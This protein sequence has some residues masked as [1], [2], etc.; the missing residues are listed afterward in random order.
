[1]KPSS[2][3]FCSGRNGSYPTAGAAEHRTV[4]TKFDRRSSRERTHRIVSMPLSQEPSG[5]DRSPTVHRLTF[6][7]ERAGGTRT[8]EVEVPDRT[9]VRAALRQAGL[10]PEGCLVLDGEEPIPLDLPA[11]S[12]RIY[13]VVPTFSGG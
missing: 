6:R 1:M 3:G 4:E 5:P 11:E 8:I 7:V 13:T 10:A 2:E 12:A 9:P